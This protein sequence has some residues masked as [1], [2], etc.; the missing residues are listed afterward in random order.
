MEPSGLQATAHTVSACPRRICSFAPVAAF[1]TRTP[2]SLPPVTTRRLSGLQAIDRTQLMSAW[3]TCRSRQDAKSHRRTVLTQPP[4]GRS[5]AGPSHV[6]ASHLPSGLQEARRERSCPDRA[7]T[8][9]PVR[10]FQTRRV[11]SAPAEAISGCL[12][13]QA[14]HVTARGCPGST[15]SALRLC[16]LQMR[17]VPSPLPDTIFMPSGL[18]A[19]ELTY[20]VWPA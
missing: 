7:R 6:N 17:S 11:S 16:A 9:S 2:R 3:S 12:G 15:F 10:V 14:T 20:S 1:H 13:D 4:R 5:T 19:T 8:C 18:Q